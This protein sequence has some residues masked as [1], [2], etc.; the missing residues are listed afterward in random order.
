[1]KVNTHTHC[2]RDGTEQRRPRASPCRTEEWCPAIGNSGG[3]RVSRWLLR[4]QWRFDASPWRLVEAG[5]AQQLAHKCTLRAEPERRVRE[6]VSRSRRDGRNSEP[7]FDAAVVDTPCADPTECRMF[8][9]AQWRFCDSVQ[10][11]AV[12]HRLPPDASPN[13]KAHAP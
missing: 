9:L 7:S 1:M 3:A 5:L 8:T 11:S 13:A 4:F 6:H 10:N 12:F 2:S